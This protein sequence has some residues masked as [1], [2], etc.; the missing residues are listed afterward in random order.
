LLTLKLVF[1]GFPGGV[2]HSMLFELNQMAS[3]EADAN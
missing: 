3:T 1:P 2:I